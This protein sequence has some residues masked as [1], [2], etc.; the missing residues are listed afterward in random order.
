MTLKVHNTATRTLETFTPLVSGRA[1]VYA[2]GPTIYN[3]AHIGNFR[4]FL[5]FDLVHR[6][7]EW[8]GYDVKFLMNLTDVDDKVIEAAHA[9]GVSIDE[10][11]G[12]FGEVFLADC[13]TLGVRPVDLYPRATH[14]IEA[15]VSFIETL[16]E[17]GHAYPAEDGA[18]YFSIESFPEYGRLKGIDSS[19]LIAGARV[20]QDEYEKEDARDFALWKGATPQDEAVG[21]AW[22]SPWGRG[23]PGWHL[24]CSVMSTAELGPTL[25]M[26]LGGEDLVFPHHENEIA[27]SECATGETF[28]RYWMHVKHLFVEG[29]KMSKS[30]G[31]FIR[32]RDLL[33]D[34]HDPAAIR[35]LLISS[36][37]RGDLNFT[38]AGLEGS[39]SAVQR[40]LNFEARLEDTAIDD[41][42]EGTELP[43]LA[44]AMVT[45]F[46]EALDHDF[47]SADGLA[48]V[49]VFVNAANAVLD[50]REAVSS[51]DRDAALSALR[52]VDQVLGLLEV[53]HASRTVD[54]DLAAWVEGKI[55]E[56]AAAR[57]AKDFATAD[58]IREELSARNIVLEDGAGG[59]RWKVTT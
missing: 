14:Y 21:A 5:F 52:D 56:R 2:C 54:D 42:A 45:S 51:A 58:A 4:T 57:A 20:E 31:N 1:H 48:A 30:L 44:A 18:V 39:Q 6:H 15:M 53:A 37:Y 24:E 22:D 25:D 33:E 16:V 36:H 27:Q 23:R 29:K 50:G 40:L 17:R 41:A 49:F 12:P 7:L 47:N 38:V 13:T 59:T 55:E 34:G 9:A 19:T 10:H 35:H 8:S 43:E 28:A 32:V 11:T 3:H 26:H 46:R